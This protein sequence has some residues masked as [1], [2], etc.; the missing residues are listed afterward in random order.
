MEIFP[1]GAKW[2]RSLH[3]WGRSGPRD[4]GDFPHWREAGEESAAPLREGGGGRW[5]PGGVH[6]TAELGDLTTTVADVLV[7][8]ANASLLGGGGVDGA[9]HAAAG[10]ALLDACRRVRRD[11]WPGGL[12]VGDAVATEAGDLPA[13]WVVHTVG[14]NRH[15]GERDPALL[16][17]CFTRALD[18]ADDLGA[19]SVAF[20][21]VSAGVYGWPMAEVARVAVAAVRG[22]RDDH[23]GSSVAEVRFVLVSRA[24]YEVFAAELA[25]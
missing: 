6:R 23:P 24:A 3:P 11:T 1:T 25:D 21:A 19:Q 20:P 13:R 22:W 5:H 17:S 2:V 16:T 18:V 10:P 14:P 9:L 15:A 12:P 4:G 7:N 8:A